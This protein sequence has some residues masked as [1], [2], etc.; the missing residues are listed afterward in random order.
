[1][2]DLAPEHR[3]II[4]PEDASVLIVEDGV[5]DFL[6]TA[7]L[8]GQM[9]VRQFSWKSSGWRFLDYL[10]TMPTVDLILMDIHVPYNDGHTLIRQLRASPQV[11]DTV[12]CALTVEASV[13]RIETAK[14]AGFNGFISKPLDRRL[15]PDQIRRLLAGEEVWEFERRPF[16][17]RIPR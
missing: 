17:S 3:V 1:M 13:N 10:L 5:H 9:G 15:F 6:L 8:L 7:R 2:S 16:Y 11:R 14:Q 4:E 12:V